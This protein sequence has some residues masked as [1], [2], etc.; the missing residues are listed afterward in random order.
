M[1]ANV[2]ISHHCRAEPASRDITRTR[3]KSGALLDALTRCNA[4][5]VLGLLRC[6]ACGAIAAISRRRHRR[7]GWRVAASLGTHVM[8]ELATRTARR[9]VNA[10]GTLERRIKRCAFGAFRTRSE[11]TTRRGAVAPCRT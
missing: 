3:R 9:G 10:L 1:V 8:R 5:R 4:S 11:F 7:T 6:T 2:T